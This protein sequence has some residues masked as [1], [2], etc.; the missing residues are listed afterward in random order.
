MNNNQKTVFNSIIS[1]IDKTYNTDY[2]KCSLIT[3]YTKF[4]KLWMMLWIVGSEAGI[5]VSQN[6]RI[7]IPRYG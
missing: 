7:L 4:I 1:D 5:P 2:N 3:D 6:L